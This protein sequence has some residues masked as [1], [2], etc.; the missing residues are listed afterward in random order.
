MIWAALSWYCACPV[1][2]L[3]GRITASDYMDSLGKQ[4]YPVV[5]MLFPKNDVIFKMTIRP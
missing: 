2:T 4:V 5:Q 3:N 1:I